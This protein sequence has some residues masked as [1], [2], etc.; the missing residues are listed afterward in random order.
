ML[1]ALL[2]AKPSFPKLPQG[3]SDDVA[4]LCFMALVFAALWAWTRS[5]SIR[6]SIG[7]LGDPRVYAVLRIGFAVMTVLCFVNL[8]PYWRMLWTDEGMFSL[9]YA[10]DRLGRSAL[11]GWTPVDGFIDPWA[12]LCFL[13]NKPSLLFLWGSPAFVYSYIAAFF[14]ILG[15]YAAG[16][17]SRITG[18]LGWFLMSGIY[19]RNALYWEGTDTVYR[20]FFFVLLFAR[21]GHA[22]S[23]DNWW[24]CRRLR[25]KGLLHEG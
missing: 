5:E 14:V 9:S 16:V 1:L 18:V 2:D 19:N 25:R 20:C 12:Y 8:G 24:R 23:F 4:T 17:S 13:W 15:L 11:R 10:Q 21:T 22:W 3:L 6:R 7:G